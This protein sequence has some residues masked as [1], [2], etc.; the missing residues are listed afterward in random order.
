MNVARSGI[1]DV[2]SRNATFSGSSRSLESPRSKLET[3]AS[4]AASAKETS[5]IELGG[6]P[7]QRLKL[8]L[9][10]TAENRQGS[11][12]DV[13]RQL[14]LLLA[15]LGEVGE[16]AFASSRW[17]ISTGAASTATEAAEELRLLL[18]SPGD[19]SL[20][21]FDLVVAELQLGDDGCVNERVGMLLLDENL[22]QSLAL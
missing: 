12:F 6:L 3:A 22:G 20:D 8:L 9:L 7:F 4:A 15:D 2:P 17:L 21:F 13:F 14:F 18:A 11:C 10:R 16:T 5:R 1:L 19:R